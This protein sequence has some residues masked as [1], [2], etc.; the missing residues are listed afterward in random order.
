MLMTTRGSNIYQFPI[1]RDIH[2]ELETAEE[3]I[4][5]ISAILSNNQP[6]GFKL[7]LIE[8]AIEE[9]HND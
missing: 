4:S 2:K 8:S 7:A 1:R 3:L 5:E 9:W 6:Y